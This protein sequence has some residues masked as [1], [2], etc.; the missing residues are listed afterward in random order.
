MSSSGEVAAV[1]VFSGELVDSGGSRIGFGSRRV[2]AAAQVRISGTS[3]VAQVSA[4]DVNLLGLLIACEPLT[5]DLSAS[6]CSVE[7]ARLLVDGPGPAAVLPVPAKE[8]LR[9]IVAVGGAGRG[10]RAGR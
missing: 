2:T 9:K 3:V 1:G 5:V 7:D 4:V 8:L 6:L 10:V